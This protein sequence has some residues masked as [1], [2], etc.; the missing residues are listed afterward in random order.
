[1][2]PLS[3]DLT[4]AQFTLP[5]PKLTAPV[6]LALLADLHSSRYGEAQERLLGMLRPLQPDLV[7]LAGDIVDDIE[8]ATGAD[9][10]LSVLGAEYR[11][12]YVSGNH[13]ARTGRLDEIKKSVAAHG[14]RVLDGRRDE[15]RLRGQ[16][17]CVCGI[18]DRSLGRDEFARQL[19]AAFDGVSRDV[20]TILLTHRPEPAKQYTRFPCDLILAGHTHGGQVRIPALRFGLYASG[21]GLFPRYS[22][23]MY[24]VG[25][26]KLLV[27]RGLSLISP[28]AP[29]LLRVPRIF[30]PPQIVAVTL[31]P[32]A[33]PSPL[34]GET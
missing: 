23:G 20:Y 16:R 10:L 9:E 24:T 30:N 31:T 27:S 29:R 32:P 3:K 21:Q 12:Y 33:S 1:M 2:K 28:H 11:A 15:V 5:T 18:D 26:A 22:A 8:P 17:V 7:F 34:S 4:V 19:G 25:D 6:R 14:V 13:E